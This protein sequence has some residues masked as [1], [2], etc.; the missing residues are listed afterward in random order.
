M[1]ALDLA[2]PGHLAWLAL[3]P[4]LY[5]LSR[6]PRPKHDHATAYLAL[7]LRARKKLRRRPIRFRWLRFVLLVLAF[8]ALILAHS[9]PSLAG[10]TGATDLVV[11]L[12]VSASMAARGEPDRPWDQ[13]RR[14]LLAALEDVPEQVDLRIGLC[15]TQ[16]EVLRGDR[17][18]LLARLEEVTPSG[19]GG[20]DFPALARQLHDESTAV[21]T[22]TDG[23]GTAHPPEV[24]SLTLVG[25][26]RHNLAITACD[27]QDDWP[28]PSLRLRV[29]VQNFGPS[30][31]LQLV[32]QG[33]VV[34]TPPTG[35]TLATGAARILSL[36]LTRSTGGRL[37]LALR[38]AA[39]GSALA[40]G[41]TLDDTVVIELP[42]P[43]RPTIA[44]R[45]EA[46][47]PKALWV[48]A[49]TL[50]HEFGGKV[51]EGSVARA[52]FLI[53]DGGALADLPSGLRML[54]F[55]TTL[56]AGSDQ[57]DRS[58]APR[59]QDWSRVD[60]VTAGLDLSELRIERALAWR[61]PESLPPGS[62][63]LLGGDAGVLGLVL[64]GKDSS[65]VHL[66]FRLGES[67]FFKL[68]AFPQFVRRAFARSYGSRAE[69]RLFGEPLL[70]TAESDLS[71]G[72]S[73]GTNPIRQTD[74]PLPV[75]A[76][77]ATRLALPLLVL[78]VLFLAVRAYV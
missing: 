32:V 23:L 56:V 51:V 10:R 37:E 61:D 64:D 72:S 57:L 21:W 6:P 4:L 11:L 59:L 7:W 9:E 8:S 44:V 48:A 74:R 68:A 16:V 65:S 62:T 35:F 63:V 33:G 69:S 30:R 20:V 75:F 60:P 49:R 26:S 71:G 36:P 5:L 13:A 19:S 27:V 73:G 15:G 28:L 52:G 47:S 42:A 46:D 70:D 40:D 45:A 12:D 53:T 17:Q 66:A 67:N 29:T 43:P 22:L 14:R 76:T 58:I 77:P 18:S 2:Q 55:G 41:L 54:S 31:N 3:L 38:D 78:A 34:R 50:A 1:D 24:G 25:A 39:D